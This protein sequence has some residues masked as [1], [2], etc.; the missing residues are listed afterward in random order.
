[1]RDRDNAGVDP[2]VTIG[3]W[4]IWFMA[5]CFMAWTLVIYGSL[6]LIEAL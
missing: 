2:S 6:A 3:T 1:M 5:S 4:L